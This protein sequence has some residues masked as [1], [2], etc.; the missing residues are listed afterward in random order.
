MKTQTE[1]L[2]EYLLSKPDRV[3]SM[4]KLISRA[5]DLPEFANQPHLETTL[6]RIIRSIPTVARMN[7]DHIVLIK[8]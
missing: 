7:C 5:S 6:T 1:A 4:R 3:M 8:E 2:T